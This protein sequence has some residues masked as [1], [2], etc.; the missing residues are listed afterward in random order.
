MK[1][2]SKKYAKLL[3]DLKLQMMSGELAE[4]SFLPSE[5]QLAGEYGLSRPTVRKAIAELAEERFIQTIPGKGSV[6][7]GTEHLEVKATVLHLYWIS[8]SNEY[9]MIRRLV[10]R[11]NEEHRHIQVRLIDFSDYSLPPSLNDLEDRQPAARPDLISLNNRLLLELQ[12]GEMAALLHPL[13]DAADTVRKSVYDFLWAPAMQNGQTYAMPLSFSPV[14]LFYNKSMFDRAG[15]EYPDSSWRWDDLR[16]AAIRL[17]DG[18]SDGTMRYGFGF[19]PSYYRWPLFFLQEGGKFAESGRAF[20]AS[21][22]SNAGVGFILDLI[23]R[24]RVTPLLYRS[25]ELSEQFFHLG[26]VGMIMSTYYLQE[27]HRDKPFEWGV[28]KFPSGSEDISLGISTHIGINRKSPHIHEAKYFIRYLLSE[29]I[30]ALIKSAGTTIPA[31][32]TVA[33]DERYSHD[34]FSGDGYYNFKDTLDGIRLVNGLGLSVSQ[35][36]RLGEDMEMVWFKIRSFREMWDSLS[37]PGED[38]P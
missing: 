11:F 12:S 18:D 6:V 22:G 21:S 25:S 28:C 30:Q 9:S 15:L 14:M 29:P 7:L 5:N 23:Y 17:T 1:A 26:K 13:E 37:R 4:G 3:A 19:S 27:T 24:E 35:M 36:T 16:R 2:G 8:P 34:A 31:V 32:R 10:E 33:E 20:P 38:A